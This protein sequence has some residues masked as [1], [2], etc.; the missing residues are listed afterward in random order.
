MWI[1][2]FWIFPVISACVWVATL[3]AMLAVWA[4]EGKPHYVSE[5]SDQTTPYVFSSL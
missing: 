1:L 5:E 4:A 3:I 2:S